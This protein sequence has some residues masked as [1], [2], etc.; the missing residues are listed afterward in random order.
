MNG[1]GMD[2]SEETGMLGL[3]GDLIRVWERR[4]FERFEQRRRI[5]NGTDTTARQQFKQSLIDR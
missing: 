5:D 2:S 4:S 3:V 1:G